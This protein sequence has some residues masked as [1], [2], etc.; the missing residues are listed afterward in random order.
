[1]I[2]T[3]IEGLIDTAKDGIVL[4]QS[5]LMAMGATGRAV[6]QKTSDDT[7]AVII[8]HDCGTIELHIPSSE[9]FERDVAG[10]SKMKF[11]DHTSSTFQESCT[12]KLNM[13]KYFGIIFPNSEGGYRVQVSKK[14]PS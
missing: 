1:M 10:L 3:V 2:E 14:I 7:N 9:K 13:E 5:Q 6:I 8:E 11:M 4:T 12:Y